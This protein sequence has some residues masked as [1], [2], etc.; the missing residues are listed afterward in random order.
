MAY[1][2]SQAGPDARRLA[3]FLAVVDAGTL[4]RAAEQLRIAQ[5][6]LS[7]AIRDLERDFG[8]PLF[9]RV[10]RRLVLN[11]TGRALVDVARQIV[12]NLASA[13]AAVEARTNLTT[14]HITIATSPSLTAEPLAML[15]GDFRKQYP[16]VTLQVLQHDPVDIRR[17]VSATEADLG[18]LVEDFGQN[19]QDQLVVHRLGLH[20]VVAVLPPGARVPEPF[21][22]ITPSSFASWPLVATEPGTRVRQL[23]DDFAA[24][25]LPVRIA[26]EVSHRESMVPLVLSGVGATLLPWSLARLAG[27]LGAVVVGLDPPVLSRMILVH[28]SQLRQAA[29]AFVDALLFGRSDIV[30]A[31]SEQPQ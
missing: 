7:L 31:E 2:L 8:A 22:R 4:T 30:I 24:D 28:R 6:S 27:R 1:E 3:Y 18:L 29:T 9:N 23:I 11:D 15:I 17:F 14:G 20:E 12:A 21:G 19:S 16:G 25:G 5:P 26:A 13:R 10:G